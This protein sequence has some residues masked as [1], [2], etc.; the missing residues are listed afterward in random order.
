MAAEA[1]EAAVVDID[2]SD[3]E[4]RIAGTD[5]TASLAEIAI[6]SF[7]DGKRP[8][9]VEAGLYGSQEFAPEAGTFPNGCHICELEVDP[10]TGVTEIVRYTIEDDVGM[11]I[12]PLLLEGQIMGGV[13]QGLGQACGEHAVYEPESGQ[14]LTATFMDYPMPRAD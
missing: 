13:A 12:N 1:L 5:R 4:F 7:D 3:G 8:D 6:A 14:L 9:G 10:E 11:V 2:F